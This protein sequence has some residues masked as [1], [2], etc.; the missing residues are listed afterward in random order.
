MFG[1]SG[2]IQALYG[3]PIAAK[4][5]VPWPGY[6]QQPTL[7]ETL[8]SI[9]NFILVPFF[10]IVGLFALLKIVLKSTSKAV[11]GTVITIY[12]FFWGK[13]IFNLLFSVQKLYGVPLPYSGS[14][15]YPTSTPSTIQ[16][17]LSKIDA[18]GNSPTFLIPL[19]FIVGFVLYFNRKMNHDASKKS[20]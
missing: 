10:F 6:Q 17:L 7:I 16:Q 1:F 2:P 5:G 18:F 3:P 4:Y 11:I 14:P 19:T 9:I 20:P 12:L 13:I 15:S 8:S